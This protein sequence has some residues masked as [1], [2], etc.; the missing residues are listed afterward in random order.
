MAP[1]PTQ[2]RKGL[3]RVADV[4]YRHRRLVVLLWLLALVGTTALSQRFGGDFTMEFTT[5]A[6]ESSRAQDLLHARFP[7]RSGDTIEVVYEAEQGIDDAQ[8]RAAIEPLLAKVTGVGHVVRVTSPYSP[9]GA[10]QVSPDRKIAF[11][12][13]QLDVLSDEMPHAV[14]R[15]IIAATESVQQPGVRVELSGF[16]VR[17]AEEQGPGSLGIGLIAAVLILLLTFGSLLAMGLPILTAVFGLGIGTALMGL[18]ANVVQT[19]DFATQV[20]EMIGIG[21]GIDYVL[22]IVTRYRSELHRG[23]PAHDAVVTAIGTAGRAVLFAGCTV[24]VSLLGLFVIGLKFLQGVAISAGA[25]VAVVMLASVTLLPAVLGFIG[26]GIDKLKVPFVNATPDGRHGFWWK[27][28]RVVQRRPWP[29]A[30]VGFVIIAA[31]ALPL[32]SIR[33]GFPDAGQEPTSSTTRRSYDLLTKGFGAGFNGPLLLVAELPSGTDS[34]AALSG[35]N[36]AI[37]QTTGVAAVTPAFP[38]ADGTVALMRIIPTTTP[39]AAATEALVKHLR[40]DVIPAATKATGVRASLTGNTAASVDINDYMAGRLALFIGT[41]VVLSFLLLLVVFRSLLVALKAAL[42][43]VLSIA[44]AYGVVGLATQGGW[45]GNLIGIHEAIPLPSFIPMMMFAILFGLSMDYE[46]FLLSRVR[47]EYV[48][49]GDNGLAVADGLA[50]T[51]RVITAA[52]AIM[53]AVFGAFVLGDNVFVK[54]VGI[55]MAAAIFVDATVVRMVLVPSTMELLGNANWWLPRWLDRI[56][57]EFHIEG[58]HDEDLD[59]ELDEL[60]RSPQPTSS[61]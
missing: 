14:T 49:T 37:G 2:H 46:V 9:E 58:T 33:F 25:G 45:F 60:V 52:A 44:A 57:P 31:L 3:L 61:R 19:P 8:V 18:I 59:G 5:P 55:G 39:Q 40:A 32:F 47:E 43:N 54:S 24:I 20:A 53:V 26:H 6:S 13:L 16:A 50:T 22:F 21:V 1:V 7:A 15:Q 38:N 42:M 51:A 4:S 35:L 36:Q 41:V 10:F 12:T 28:S 56:L 34:Q 27:W 17:Q 23:R 11:A 48:R 30:I 29:M